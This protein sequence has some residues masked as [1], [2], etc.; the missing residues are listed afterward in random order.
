MCFDTG[1]ALNQLEDVDQVGA[2]VVQLGLDRLHRCARCL[3]T[4]CFSGAIV[5]EPVALGLVM[6]QR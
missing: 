1:I 6:L 3:M 2:H 5:T 4:V